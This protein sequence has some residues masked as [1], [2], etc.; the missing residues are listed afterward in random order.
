[1]A[2]F[3]VETIDFQGFAAYSISLRSGARAIIACYGA[4]ILSWKPASGK[5]W[6]YLSEDALFET[7]KAI[8]GG[9]PISFPQFSSLGSLPKHGFLRLRPWTLSEQKELDGTLMLSFKTEDDEFSRALWPHS[10]LAEL[11]V[12]LADERLDIE[13]GIENTGSEACSFTAA[14]HTYF[15]VSDVEDVHISGLRG[16]EYRDAANED[17]SKKETGD[18]VLLRGQ[19]DRVYHAAPDTLMLKEPHR[20]LAIHSENFPDVV[21]WNP[22]AEICKKMSDM[23]PDD[24]QRMLCIEAAAVQHPIVLAAGESWWGRQTLLD[25]THAPVGDD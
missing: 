14:L 24:Y 17:A 11:T 21:L 13:L 20:A 4:Q 8:R 22:G 18:V 12:V 25:L 19:V 1:M 5:E 2:D 7:G 23:P 10:F 3:K 16:V 15:S 9:V 6:L